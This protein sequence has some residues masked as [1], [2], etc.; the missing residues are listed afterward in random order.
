MAPTNGDQVE[1]PPLT[2]DQINEKLKNGI[3]NVNNA[4][5]NRIAE[6]EGTLQQMEMRGKPKGG[7]PPV[8]GKNAEK[9]TTWSSFLSRFEA[10]C[11]SED[12][13]K[14]PAL[15]KSYLYQSIMGSAANCIVAI[16]PGTA[17]YETSTFREYADKLDLIFRPASDAAV[18]KAAYEDRIQGEE[19][20]VQTFFVQKKNLWCLAFPEE[21]PETSLRLIDDTIKGLSNKGVVKH[22]LA[23]RPYTSFERC[24]TVAQSGVAMQRQLN[25]MGF[26]NLTKGLACSGPVRKNLAE[27]AVYQGGKG[28]GGEP[29]DIGAVVAENDDDLIDLEMTDLIAAATTTGGFSGSCYKCGKTGHMIRNCNMPVGWRRASRGRPWTTQWTPRGRRGQARGGPR[30]DRR[31]RFRPT[32]AATAEY[33]EGEEVSAEREAEISELGVE[34]DSGEEPAGFPSRD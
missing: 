32:V 15:C 11:T 7:H 26:E 2:Q 16:K 21:D 19:E 27:Y 6:L 29:M 13:L 9:D 10:W 17:F 30:R 12:V 20:S 33:E 14:N 8:W 4:L 1:E 18:A 31:G 34:N 25:S 3:E 5:L 22:I 24:L 28:G 23:N